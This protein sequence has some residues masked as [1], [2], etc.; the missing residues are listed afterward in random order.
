MYN[1]SYTNKFLKDLKLLKKRSIKDFELTTNFIQ[2][3][4]AVLGANNLPKKYRA[5][6]LSGNYQNNW[7][8]H[9]KPDLLIIWLE[10]NTDNEITL[11]RIGTHSDLF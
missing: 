8:C 1:V 2:F 10:V 11:V 5:H 3:E 7:E 9:I 6:K 4:L